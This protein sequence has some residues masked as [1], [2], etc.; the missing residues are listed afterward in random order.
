MVNM[1][2]PRRSVFFSSPL[3]RSAVVSVLLLVGTIASATEPYRLVKRA[4]RQKP[5]KISITTSA[6]KISPPDAAQLTFRISG[7]APAGPIT[8]G[9]ATSGTAIEG[10]DY[11]MNGGS[12]GIIIPAGSTSANLII[13]AL[14]SNR[15]QARTFTLRLVGGAGYKVATPTRSS[16][17]LAAE[18]VS[19]VTPTPSPAATPIPTPTPNPTPAP[20]PEREI[21]IA[22]RGDGLPGSGTQADPFDGSTPA[23][24]DAI[25]NRYQSTPNLGIHLSGAGPF[26]TDVHH[27]WW[28]RSG[29]LLSGDGM[30][31]TTLQLVGL[32]VSGVSNNIVLATDPNVTTDNVTVRDL[33]IDCNWPEIEQTAP[34]GTNG[35]SPCTVNAVTLRGS[36]NLIERVRH[37]NSYGSREYRREGFAMILTSSAQSPGV[38]DIIRDCRAEL[39]RGTYGNPFALA[40]TAACPITN[41]KVVGCTA[42]GINDGSNHGFTSGGVNLAYVK[43]CEVDGNTFI[44]CYG[45]GYLDVGTIDGL[46]V[47]NNTVVRGWM[48]VAF[49]SVLDQ[50]N[51]NI[52]NNNFSIQNR[53]PSGSS[54]G[55][56]IGGAEQQTVPKA[57][58]SVTINSNTI[59]FDTSGLGAVSF[60]GIGTSYL[61]NAT[62]S[63]NTI[64]VA[65]PLSNNAVGVGVTLLNN[66][67][68]DGSPVTWRPY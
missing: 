62:I 65:Y 13:S 7:A 5:P 33:T 16:I 36:N 15:S 32:L 34:N 8:V 30:Y 9:Y 50:R 27:P 23:Q 25:L 4:P 18:P 48:G 12:G 3:V 68:S 35:E 31:S 44:D 57:N 38:N 26:R 29:W 40:G 67:M 17:I 21:W 22:V 11:A 6:R 63:N 64:G 41:S 66:I 49:V 43:D 53:V 58:S 52:S 60:W 47:T 28:L 61:N 39:P 46:R 2:N 54:F 56:V 1:K 59:S 37:I 14:H 42:V 45:A 24:F 51:I 10:Q 20:T 19:A 55:V